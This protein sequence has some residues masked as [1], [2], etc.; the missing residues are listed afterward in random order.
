[1]FRENYLNLINIIGSD[2]CLGELKINNFSPHSYLN[3]SNHMHLNKNKLHEILN[4]E[5]YNQLL[6]YIE[7]GKESFLNSYNNFLTFIKDNYKEVNLNYKE[8]SFFI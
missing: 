5:E 8:V 7:E 3:G 6:N 2:T 1:M 4:W